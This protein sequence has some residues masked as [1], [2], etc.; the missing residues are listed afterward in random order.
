MNR[1]VLVL[2]LS[3]SL[4]AGCDSALDNRTPMELKDRYPDLS[5]LSFEIFGKAGP[6]GSASETLF[7]E[8]NTAQKAIGALSTL[9]EYYDDGGTL[10]RDV[11][12]VIALEG[13]PRVVDQASR[14]VRGATRLDIERIGDHANFYLQAA[15]YK[16]K[17]DPDN[18]I[19]ES[20][21]VIDASTIP[22][23]VE[24]QRSST[25]GAT[26]LASSSRGYMRFYFN[27]R[28]ED[29]SAV[30]HAAHLDYSFKTDRTSLHLLY[31]VRG[32]YTAGDATVAYW[33]LKKSDGYG[34][35][36]VAA[37]K[38]GSI[39]YRV[40]GQHGPQGGYAVWGGDGKLLACYDNGGIEIG[41]PT[42]TAG[43]DGF[44]SAF[45]A[46]PAGPKIW[47]ALPAGIPK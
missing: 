24:G 22:P 17:Y 23:T 45:T 19:G 13:A 10:D 25:K 7:K 40:L 47:P 2:S 4:V 6:V 36:Y 38:S 18:A 34:F 37:Q 42:N 1:A 3:L 32:D 12:L 21:M 20:H 31:T 35:I 26:G 14:Y 11:G 44:K 41:G 39:A 15:D 30:H 9:A 28:G 16:G 43:C 29:A 46:P 8:I 27:H 5:T 33:Y